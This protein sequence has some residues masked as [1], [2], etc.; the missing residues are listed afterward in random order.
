MK[1]LTHKRQVGKS[2]SSPG[3]KHRWTAADLP[4]P[5]IID[6][7][8]GIPVLAAYEAEPLRWPGSYLLHVPCPECSRRK[9]V[10]HRHGGNQTERERP[11]HRVAHCPEGPYW[12]HGYYIRNVAKW[13]RPRPRK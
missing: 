5:R 4:Q 11:T 8:D 6:W 9:I 13:P 10:I 1:T 3:R 12:E 2:I 7:I